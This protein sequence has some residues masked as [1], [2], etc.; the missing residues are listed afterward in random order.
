MGE[1][2][3]TFKQLIVEAGFAESGLRR[4]DC[5]HFTMK[6]IESISD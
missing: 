4:P 6:D 2:M 5:L 3:F 1:T